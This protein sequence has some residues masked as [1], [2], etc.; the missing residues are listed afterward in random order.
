MRRPT[1]ASAMTG[2]PSRTAALQAMLVSAGLLAAAAAERRPYKKVARAKAQEH[3]QDAL[4]DAATDEFFAGNWLQV[5]LESL[6]AKA[7]VT[8]QTL[9]RHFGSKDGL[10][11]QALA[12]GATQVRD[13]RW[14]TPTGDVAGAVANLL[15][16]Y[17]AW[18]ERSIRIGEWQRGPAM[19]GMLSRVARQVH[20]EWIEYAF[21]PWL[22]DIDE[23]ARTRRRAALIALC[24]V[25]TWW[26][27]SH[28][29]ELERAEVHATL[30]DTIERLLAEAR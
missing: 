7:G 15:D 24:D 1:D 22:Q 16:H 12:R 3:T 19:L 27:M 5:S 26:T 13:Q 25:Q 6:S 29:L 28:D 8:K 11:M 30:T 20:Y 9:L 18:G 4:I 10:L 17:E 14:S 23:P 21:A 2:Q